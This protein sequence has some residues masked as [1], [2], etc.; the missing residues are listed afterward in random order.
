MDALLRPDYLL[1]LLEQGDKSL[2]DHTRLF[3]L[4][5][6]TTSYL[7]DTLCAF[8]DASLNIA[9]RALLSEDG[10]REDFAAFKG[11]TLARHGSPFTV[12][13]KGDLTLRTQHPAPSTPSS[14]MPEPTVDGEPELAAVDEPSPHGTTEQQITAELE[15]HMTSV[16][17]CEPPTRE[18]AE[19]S[20]IAKRSSAHCNLAEGEL[21]EDLGLLE[22]EEDSASA[23]QPSSST[24]APSSLISAVARQSAGSTGL[25]HPTASG[26]R[27]PSCAT[28]LHSFDCTSSLS[29][30]G[31][32]RLLDP[33]G[34]TLVLC[35]SGSM[36]PHQSPESFVPPWPSGSSS[37]P[38]LI[39][40][41][42]PSVGPLELSALP[43]PWLL[44]LL[45]PPLI[46]PVR[47][48]CC[49]RTNTR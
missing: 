1:L 17:M 42:P 15:L 4:L 34:S 23:C 6:N 40:S 44:P 16:Q 9:C 35:R 49:M 31:S 39:G 11:W 47:S 26:C 10:A 45:A 37:S 29:P 3:L 46:S 19:A 12:S 25:P 5:A 13:A 32:V 38:W 21:V 27:Q 48:T 20:G 18:N 30:S 28:G 2:E 22:A 8:Y 43:S 33:S 7:D 14:H 41:P 36:P 24:M